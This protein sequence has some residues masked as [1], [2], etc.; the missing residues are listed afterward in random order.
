MAS[1]FEEIVA[2]IRSV[3]DADSVTGSQLADGTLAWGVMRLAQQE[4]DTVRRIV[5]IPVQFEDGP[6]TATSM[7]CAGAGNV[8]RKAMYRELWDVECHIVGGS[9]EDTEDLRERVLYAAREALGRASTP[10]GGV[11]V[12]QA[13]ADAAVMFAGA[14]KVVQRF[15]WDMLAL[16]PIIDGGWGTIRKIE[17]TTTDSDESSRETF[18]IT[19]T[20]Q[21]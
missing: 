16:E 17:T 10:N 14:E 13:M 4:H 3:L 19:P 7:R 20:P 2:G 18:E 5:W 6:L 9:L 15:K 11:W 1:V 12:T 21:P 8:P